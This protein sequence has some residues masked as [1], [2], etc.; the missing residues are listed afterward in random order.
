M[1]DLLTHYHILK[2]TKTDV[3]HEGLG[4]CFPLL[5]KKKVLYLRHAVLYKTEKEKEMSPVRKEKPL[6]C[7]HPVLDCNQEINI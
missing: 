2:L 5:P 6:L 4:P 3:E 1:K 7:F